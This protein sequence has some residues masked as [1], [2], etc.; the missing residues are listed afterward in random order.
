MGTDDQSA[1]K[2]RSKRGDVRSKHQKEKGK[3]EKSKTGDGDVSPSLS[4]VSFAGNI[5]SANIHLLP[6]PSAEQ[7]GPSSFRLV[8]H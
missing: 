8:V 3:K 2:G 7:R 5:C 6:F 1:G 4:T